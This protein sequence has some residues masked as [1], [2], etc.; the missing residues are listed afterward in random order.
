MPVGISRCACLFEGVIRHAWIGG[1][2]AHP[3]QGAGPK[4]ACTL[5]WGASLHSANYYIVYPG[6]TPENH[7][8]A[9][10]CMIHSKQDWGC[11]IQDPGTRGYR[12]WKAADV[13]HSARSTRCAPLGLDTVGNGLFCNQEESPR[14]PLSK[15]RTKSATTTTTQVTRASVSGSTMHKLQY[16][17]IRQAAQTVHRRKRVLLGQ[18]GRGGG[19]SGSPCQHPRWAGT[20]PAPLIE[21][22]GGNSSK[23][24]RVHRAG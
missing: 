17:T 20:D 24:F 8:P 22:A 15:K 11:R 18:G 3:L 14:A 9:E 23:D 13:S 5:V 7:P 16:S 1:L 4:I 6:N 10:G 2:G 21:G 12:W 19:G